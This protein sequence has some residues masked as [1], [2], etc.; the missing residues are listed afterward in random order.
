MLIKCHCG[1]EFEFEAGEQEFY[2]QKGFPLPKRCA[3]CR[4]KKRE[5]RLK[6][7][8]DEGLEKNVY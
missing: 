5:E 7:E 1:K 4:K 8:I 2:A 3:E 6:L